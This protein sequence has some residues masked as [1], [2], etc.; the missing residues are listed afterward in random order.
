MAR[1]PRLEIAMSRERRKNLRIEWNSAATFYD[2]HDRRRR[3]CIVGNFSNGGAKISGVQPETVPDEFMLRI[4]PHSPWRKCHVIWRSADALGVEFSDRR[5]EEP[6][7]RARRKFM[8]VVRALPQPAAF[9]RR[10]AMAAR[11]WR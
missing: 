2:R 3:S 7:G 1:Y 9:Q 6:M 5:V 11:H 8:P 4:T 10:A